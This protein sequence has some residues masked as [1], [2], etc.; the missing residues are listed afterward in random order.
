MKC[1]V[2]SVQGNWKLDSWI[3]LWFAFFLKLVV[4]PTLHFGLNWGH[5][6]NI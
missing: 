5:V 1:I 6:N 4:G 2:H 3:V